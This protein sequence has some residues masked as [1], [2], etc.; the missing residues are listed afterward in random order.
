[1]QIARNV[2]VRAI[3]PA[4]RD[5]LVARNVAALVKPP[6]GRRP[7]RPSR[8]L[9]LEQAT[10]LMDA[11]K[12]TRLEAYI[13]LSLL[14]GLRTEEARAL[15]WDHIV[16]WTDGQWRTV[17]EIG[18][19]HGQVAVFVWRSDQTGSDTK[20]PKSRRTLA[21][22]RRCV[23]ALREQKTRQAA[24]HLA[25]RP[26]WQTN[27]LVFASII[28]TPLDNHSVR[29][30]FRKITD[31]AGLG[32]IWVPRELRHTFVSLLSATACPSRRL[33]C[34]PG[35]TRQPPPNWCTGIR[36]CVP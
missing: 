33:P 29:R 21:L 20:T 35:T 31:S 9:T 34:L 19:D 27:N 18:F 28:G 30:Q 32:T 16:A 8:A 4:E 5:G 15:R 10:V 22:A 36:S 23:T 6:R 12:G 1:V 11:A 17:S 14:A 13:A 3:R 24:D 2:L 26:L 7:G 25:A